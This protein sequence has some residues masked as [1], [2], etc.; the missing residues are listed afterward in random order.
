MKKSELK[1]CPHTDKLVPKEEYILEPEAKIYT[2]KDAG[3]IERLQREK[4]QLVEV[5][6][7]YAEVTNW[8][9]IK[10]ATQDFNTLI[11]EREETDGCTLNIGG[12]RA[13]TILIKLGLY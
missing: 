2:A 7:F 4:H 5:L 9:G 1:Y 8:S 11:S 6:K 13:R 3:E 10:L 12:V